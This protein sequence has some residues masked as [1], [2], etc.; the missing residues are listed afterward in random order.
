[1]KKQPAGVYLN[2]EKTRK[3]LYECLEPEP[4]CQHFSAGFFR[5][6]E[7]NRDCPSVKDIKYSVFLI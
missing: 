6:R 2:F 5:R 1:M 7:F 4:A 3:N